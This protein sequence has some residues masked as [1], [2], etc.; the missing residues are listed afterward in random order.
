L[1]GA[2]CRWQHGDSKSRAVW[3]SLRTVRDNLALGQRLLQ[4]GDRV[5]GHLHARQVK[6][7]QV[8]EVVKRLEARVGD[9]AAGQRELFDLLE[10]GQVMSEQ[11]GEGRAAEPQFVQLGQ[12]LQ[13]RYAGAADGAAVEDEAAEMASFFWAR[14]SQVGRSS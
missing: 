7:A 6:L 12:L 4:R 13:R 8:G 10:F 9:A 3:E 14:A 5:G 11:V 1:D 2:L